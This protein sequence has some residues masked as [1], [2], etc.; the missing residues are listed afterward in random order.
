M[1]PIED[2][3]ITQEEQEELDTALELYDKYYK[4]GQ[5]HGVV[6][7]VAYLTGVPVRR[8]N[9]AVKAQEE[10]EMTGYNLNDAEA[11]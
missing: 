1:E 9:E 6:A 2:T 8:L 10:F 3:P 7:S 5:R 4:P 11:T